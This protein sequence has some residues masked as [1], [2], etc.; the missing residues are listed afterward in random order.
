[1]LSLHANRERVRPH[2]TSWEGRGAPV[3]E[4]ATG[5]DRVASCRVVLWWRDATRKES[6]GVAQGGVEQWREVCWSD[7]GASRR[8]VLWRG[9][10]EAA[11]SARGAWSKGRARKGE[12]GGVRRCALQKERRPPPPPHPMPSPRSPSPWL[13]L[14][15]PLRRLHPNEWSIPLLLS[16]PL[17]LSIPIPL[18]LSIQKTL[19]LSAQATLLSSTPLA[20][21]AAAMRYRLCP[22][23]GSTPFYCPSPFCSPSAP[24]TFH[25]PCSPP[26]LR[27]CRLAVAP[28]PNGMGGGGRGGGSNPLRRRGGRSPF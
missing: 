4:C 28:A 17:V 12:P 26:P 8:A 7:G 20:R 21:G 3:V 16:I 24:P 1:M 23:D 19:L 22:N 25:P 15:L 2:S 18:P 6:G 10:R 11:S 9:E 13:I 14:S 27:C 5:G